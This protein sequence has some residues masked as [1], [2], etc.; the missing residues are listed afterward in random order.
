V[1][2]PVWELPIPKYDGAKGK[3]L[4]GWGASAIITYQSGFPIRVWD[5]NDTELESSE[6]FESANTPTI[7]GSPLF[8]NPKSSANV[9]N[10]T[11]FF[12][13]PNSFADATTNSSLPFGV[14]GNSPHSLCC[15]PPISDTDLV[16][17]KKTPISE[18]WNTQFANPD[19]NF[20]DSTFGQILKTRIDSR[21]MQFGLK[22]L[23]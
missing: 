4:D 14:F 20:A 22:L 1:F 7:V 18:R 13:N 3:A 16:I 21:V 19:G 10:G 5:P 2:S 17:S 6:F 9:A 23:F 12:L 15:G 11:P 8:E